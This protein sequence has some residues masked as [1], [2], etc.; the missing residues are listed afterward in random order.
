MH[1]FSRLGIAEIV[2]LGRLVHTQYFER[3]ARELRVGHRGLDRDDQA[4]APEQRHEPRQTRSGYDVRRVLAFDLEPQCGQVV[5]GLVEYLRDVIV[6]A[7]HLEHGAMPFAQ[8]AQVVGIVVAHLVA[9]AGSRIASLAVR[10]IVDQAGMPGCARRQDHLECNPAVRI[11]RRS[12]VALGSDGDFAKKILIAVSG[13]ETLLGTG[14]FGRDPSAAHAMTGFHLEDVGKVA[15]QRNLEVKADGL[16][17]IVDQLEILVHAAANLATYREPQRVCRDRA[18]LGGDFAVGQKNARRKRVGG[19]A[20]EQIPR[21]AVGIDRPTADDT[22]IEAIQAFLARPV[23]LAVELADENDVPL[24]NREL[25]GPH[26]DFERHQI[27][28]IDLLA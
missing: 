8:A 14:P 7:F 11:Q 3:A 27:L 21:F 22:C 6:G 5:G 12:V 28:L 16:V 15:A 24:V 13:G 23:D 9:G 26:L 4:V 2:A 1:D 18:A 20:V 17:A 25:W 10:E 19:A